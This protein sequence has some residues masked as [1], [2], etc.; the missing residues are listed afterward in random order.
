MSFDEDA[1]KMERDVLKF[2]SLQHHGNLIELIA[3]YTWGRE[4]NFVFPF[5]EYTLYDV[6][7]GN[8]SPDGSSQSYQMP[9][10]WLWKEM[11]CVA[12]ALQQIH[13]PSKQIVTPEEGIAGC[14]HFDLK[15]ANI[16]VTND[17]KLKITDFG[18][19]TIKLALDDS[20]RYGKYTGGDFT[21][22]PP[23]VR[24]M[25]NTGP[26]REDFFSMYAGSYRIR[27]SRVSS[28]DSKNIYES[29]KYDVW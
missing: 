8:W 12:D 16:L 18:Q 23:E 9:D 22:Q 1:M 14:F 6:I 17:R 25:D 4:V 24:G 20:Q 7:H 10:H 29:G 13:N 15:P 19:S 21:Y 27:S 26:S 11:I 28:D 2:M 3:F 5:V